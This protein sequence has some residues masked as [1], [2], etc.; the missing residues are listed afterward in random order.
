MQGGCIVDGRLYIGQGYPLAK[1]V[2]LNVVD[3]SQEKLIKRYNLLENGVDWEP[4]GCFYYDGSIMLSHEKGICRIEEELDEA[5]Q[6]G[7]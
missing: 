2:Y 1:Y 6:I 5:T 7:Y 4:E 3:L